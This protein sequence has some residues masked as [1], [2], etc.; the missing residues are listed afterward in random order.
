MIKCD[1]NGCFVSSIIF[2]CCSIIKQFKLCDDIVFEIDLI[3]WRSF[4]RRNTQLYHGSFASER[5]LL[6]IRKFG[7]FWQFVLVHSDKMLFITKLKI[8][9]FKHFHSTIKNVSR[10]L[11]FKRLRFMN[12]Q[13]VDSLVK[14][15]H[16]V[17]EK[18]ANTTTN[19]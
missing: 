19:H 7:S 13:R 6:F 5:N 9:F 12:L 8:I 4:H 3:L 16:K 18:F 11:I 1:V 10:Y 15:R 17:V 14:I 2:D